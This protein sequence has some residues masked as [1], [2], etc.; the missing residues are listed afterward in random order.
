[1]SPD[2]VDKALIEK[3]NHSTD[4]FQHFER[5]LNLRIEKTINDE[6][7]ENATND[8][9]LELGKIE[10]I[11]KKTKK[12]LDFYDIVSLE[13]REEPNE[14]SI[15]ALKEDIDEEWKIHLEREKAKGESENNA[16]L[17]C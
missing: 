1:M 6:P 8:K 13:E 3:C 15:K 7:S 16:E 10:E 2:K 14:D 4:L 17:R 9:S 12:V 5:Y 11:K